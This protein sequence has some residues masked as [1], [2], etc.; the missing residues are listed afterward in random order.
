MLSSHGLAV[1]ATHPIFRKL[2]LVCGHLDSYHHVSRYEESLASLRE[3]VEATP[4][5]AS[6]LVG[7]D[8][9]DALGNLSFNDGVFVGEHTEGTPSW[10]GRRFF[11][12]CCELQLTA[13]NTFTMGAV[14]QATCFYDGK[15][16]PRQIDYFLV[17]L[18]IEL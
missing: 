8:A 3:L 18:R 11:R 12:L 14:G 4:R 6:V 16:Q 2:W 13:C 7:V 10:K 1:G 17:V 15:S 5:D 9:N